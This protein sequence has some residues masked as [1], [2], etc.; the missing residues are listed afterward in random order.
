MTA[1]FGRRPGWDAGPVRKR[2]DARTEAARRPFDR[3]VRIRQIAFRLPDSEANA[4]PVPI[5]DVYR[6]LAGDEGRNELIFH[7]VLAALEVWGQ[8]NADRL[9]R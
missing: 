2:V 3:R 6:A 5:Q 1:S 9:G 8:L 7:D 4:V